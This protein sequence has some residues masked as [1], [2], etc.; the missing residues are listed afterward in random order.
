[1]LKYLARRS[2]SQIDSYCFLS[3]PIPVSLP[4]SLSFSFFFS[5]VSSS[6]WLFGI[7]VVFQNL[8][9][10]EKEDILQTCQC[11]C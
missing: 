9:S 4:H 10:P 1:M 8:L 6:I 3:L 11:F 2:S 7:L 5:Y